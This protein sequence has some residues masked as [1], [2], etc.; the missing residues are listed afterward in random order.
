MSKI[1]QFICRWLGI[2]KDREVL[3]EVRQYA[4]KC[5]LVHQHRIDACDKRLEKL[6]DVIGKTIR[7]GFDHHLKQPSW[8]VVA[9]RDNKGREHVHFYEADWK[10]ISQ[11]N[12]TLKSFK[13]ENVIVDTHPGIAPHFKW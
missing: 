8:I 10:S 1:Q 12:D 2:E 11:I 5:D 7:A 13:R 4:L 9:W 6:E 3:E